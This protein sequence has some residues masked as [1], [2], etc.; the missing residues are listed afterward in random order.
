MLDLC[1]I[2]IWLLTI[3]TNS[4]TYTGIIQYNF[5]TSTFSRTYSGRFQY[6]GENQHLGGIFGPF[7]W[8]Y[9]I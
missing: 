7:Y 3:D 5:I 4:R 1:N 6:R 9:P 8:I 2:V